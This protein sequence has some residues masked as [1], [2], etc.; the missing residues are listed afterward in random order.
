M[1]YQRK[2]LSSHPVTKTNTSQPGYPPPQKETRS[3]AQILAEERIPRPFPFPLILPEAS[4][5]HSSAHMRLGV[6][7]RRH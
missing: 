1:T 5:T 7:L 3:L 4:L 6:F 2:Y